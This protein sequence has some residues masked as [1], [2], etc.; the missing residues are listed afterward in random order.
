MGIF[1][2]PEVIILKESNEAKE[3]LA[4]LQEL[5][6]RASGEVASKIEREI[7]VVNAGIYGEENILFELK[8]S[9]MDLVVLH[10]LYLKTESGLTA[11]IDYLV[12]TPKF[13]YVIECKNLVGNIEINNNGDFIRTFQYGSRKHKEG[14][15]SPITQNERHLNVL[16]EARLDGKNILMKVLVNATFGSVYK[17]IVVLANPKTVVNDRF[18]KKEVKE[19][20]IRADQLI[21]YI[22]ETNQSYKGPVMSLKDLLEIGESYLNLDHP[23]R[24]DYLEKYEDLVR[25]TEV[26]APSAAVS[27]S[28]DADAVMTCPR[29]GSPLVMRTAKKGDNAGNQFYGCSAFPKC[30]Y[31]KNMEK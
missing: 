10:D 12:L 15:Y 11:Q 2:K 17:G 24:P 23:D 7:A 22:R 31:V 21:S 27:P 9:G 1:S 18:A 28:E 6:P 5:L 16:K 14:I 29:C 20:V 19:K 13:Y 26:T 25:E 3:Y 8:N 30:R 4:K